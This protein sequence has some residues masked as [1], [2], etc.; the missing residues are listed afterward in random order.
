MARKLVLLLA[1]GVLVW[2]QLGIAAPARA[3]TPITVSGTITDQHGAPVPF[4]RVEAWGKY[5]RYDE[6]EFA[7]TTSD[8]EGRYSL[9]FDPRKRVAGVTAWANHLHVSADG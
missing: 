8:G 4:A 1:C 2:G 3:A 7:A 9:T 6:V 5:D